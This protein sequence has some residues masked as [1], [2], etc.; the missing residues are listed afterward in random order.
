M[1][2]AAHLGLAALMAVVAAMAAEP[3]R[4]QTKTATT[5]G[6]AQYPRND[7]AVGYEV[8]ASWPERPLRHPWEEVSGVTLDRQGRVWCLDR[9][10][11]PV[12]VFDAE[13]RL[14][15]AW[16][17][18]R[19]RRPHQI[20]LD[21][22]GNVWVVDAGDHVVTK[23]TPEGEPLLT[24]GT[25]GTPGEDATHFNQPT[26]L[27]ITPEGHLFVSDGYGNN[28]VVHFDAEGR[29]VHSWGGLG[30]RPGEFSLPHAIALDRRGR[31]YVADRNNAR[32]QVFDQDGNFIDQWRN[33]IVP[34]DIE[35]TPDDSVYVC[36][37]SPMRWGKIPLPGTVLGVPP[38]DQ[39]V[40]RFDTDGRPR[41]LWTFPL[42]KEHVGELEWVHGLAVDAAGNLYLG[43]IQGR[44][45]Q[46]FTRLDP[47]PSSQSRT[48]GDQ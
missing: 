8:D 25:P 24:L 14:V 34:W 12:Q 39:L 18:D 17:H 48:E 44:R 30:V 6:L 20:E 37:S 47:H 16:G 43:D 35:I 4:A 45:L 15:Q 33:L 38:K 2:R 36:G 23:F 9:G 13:G 28:R 10:K 41:E 19:F 26:G 27:A 46:K 22:A 1:S 32:V 29:Y 5:L 7:L 11:V 42:G 21:R 40:M 31:L 3:A